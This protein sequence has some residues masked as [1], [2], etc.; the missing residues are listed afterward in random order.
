MSALIMTDP[1]NPT[2]RELTKRANP[3]LL[4]LFVKRASCFAFLSGKLEKAF[5]ISSLCLLSV[6]FIV[7]KIALGHDK[8]AELQQSLGGTGGDTWLRALRIS[9]AEETLTL[10]DSS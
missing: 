10:M 3:A 9:K 5:W 1:K 8:Q 4:D 2:A 7:D 6:G